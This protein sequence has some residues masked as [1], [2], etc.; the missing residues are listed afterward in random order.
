MLHLV[1]ILI[2]LCTTVNGQQCSIQGSCFAMNICSATEL[3]F[4][5]TNSISLSQYQTS[6]T[7]LVTQCGNIP[8]ECSFGTNYCQNICNAFPNN[9]SC[10]STNN[11]TTSTNDDANGAAAPIETTSIA[12]SVI[13]ILLPLILCVIATILAVRR[14]KHNG[15]PERSSTIITAYVLWFLLGFLGVHR[16]YLNKICTG[17]LYA[18]TGGLF[19][20]GLLIDLCLIPGLV[21]EYFTLRGGNNIIINSPSSSPQLPMHQFGVQ[22]FPMQQN[23]MQQQQQFAAQQYPTIQQQQ[24]VQPLQQQYAQPP[25]MQQQYAQPPMQ[26]EKSI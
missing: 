20:I 16:C 24:Y 21:D 26:Q 19:G 4:E 5:C 25:M 13:I 10:T 15:V 17:L 8:V 22:Q 3:Y 1:L 11:P 12:I 9:P 18:L 23:P 2:L 14:A 7:N 6:C